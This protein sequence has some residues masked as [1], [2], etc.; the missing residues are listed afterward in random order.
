MFNLN[1]LYNVK[2]IV[3][4]IDFFFVCNK[5]HA[6]WINNS[7]NCIQNCVKCIYV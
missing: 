1:K 4:Q 2:L 5:P 7:Y 3:G 6:N